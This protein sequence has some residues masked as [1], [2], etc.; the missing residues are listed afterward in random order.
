MDGHCETLECL[1]NSPQRLRI[2]DIL[3]G[4]EMDVRDLMTALNSPRSTVQH[5]LSK[6]EERDWIDTTASG[7]TATTVG[8]LLCELFVTTG[9]TADTIQRLA[10]FFEAID[11]PPEVEIGKL[12]DALMTTPNP[13]QPNAP[14]KRLFEA[15]D[16]ADRVC[17]FTPVVSGFMVELFCNG[18]RTIAEHEYIVADEVFDILHEEF[19]EERID[20]SEKDKS[21]SVT[22]YLYEGDIPYGLF[23]SEE[24]LVLVAYD[25]TGRLQALV[26][27]TNEEAVEWG[28]RMYETYKYES[29]EPMIDVQPVARDAELID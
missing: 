28:E 3:N 26:E 15:F 29:T 18:D 23:I 12:T 17:G 25:E 9:E 11:V 6:L 20:M 13:T 24:R 16:G 21:V 2:L 19:P 7:Y 4:T 14:T 22:T 27:S 8:G 5:N 10:P 1:C